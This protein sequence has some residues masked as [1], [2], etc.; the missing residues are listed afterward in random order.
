MDYLISNYERVFVLFIEHILLTFIT[1]LFSLIISFPL[2]IFLESKDRLEKLISKLFGI[3]YTIPS[4][5]FF[6]IL[7]PITGLGMKS[8]VIALVTYTQ[9]I[10]LRNIVKGLREVPKEI[11]ESA[12]G[13]GMSRKDLLFKI[14]IPLAMPVILAGFRIS[15]I[16]IISI[17]TIAAWINAGGLGELIFEGL[18]QNY[19]TKIIV[20][21]ILVAI[22]S[23]ISNSIIKKI[24]DIYGRHLN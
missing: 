4:L 21:T 18:S 23:I 1:L 5:A 7:V 3:F 12:C 9:F 11:I 2:G 13:M 24:E 8:A 17:S 19:S 15:T 14:K 16:S 20:G 22:L 6:A 10:L